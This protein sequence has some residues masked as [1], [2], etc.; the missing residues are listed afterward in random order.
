MASCRSMLTI[1]QNPKL[2]PKRKKRE[3]NVHI[4]SKQHSC[5]ILKVGDPSKTAWMINDKGNKVWFRFEHTPSLFPVTE[6]RFYK[7]KLHKA[8]FLGKNAKDEEREI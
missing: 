3:K 5:S 4:V 8:D 2:N 6:T 7:P 1:K